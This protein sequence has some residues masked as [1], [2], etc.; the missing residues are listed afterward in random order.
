MKKSVGGADTMTVMI[1]WRLPV[2]HYWWRW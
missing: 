2:H 1:V